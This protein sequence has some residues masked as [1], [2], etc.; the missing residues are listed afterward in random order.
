[1]R[2][3][4]GHFGLQPAGIQTCPCRRRRNAPY[5]RRRPL[6]KGRLPGGHRPHPATARKGPTACRD[7]L[8]DEDT[9][10]TCLC[11]HRSDA[12]T[13][14]GRERL[15]FDTFLPPN[16][17]DRVYFE[18]VIRWRTADPP[19]TPSELTAALR[20]EGCEISFPRYPLL[21]Q[22]PL[23]T[24]GLFTRIT[25]PADNAAP[26]PTF[27]TDALPATERANRELLRLPTFPGP[28]RSLI[29]QYAG[30]FEKV[31]VHASKIRQALA[32]TNVC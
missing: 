14:S 27:R 22:Q 2:K 10:G 24:E 13:A 11:G 16:H 31:L 29:D 18:F 32:P 1:M 9:D 7:Q 26:V 30:A 21:H 23:F 15:G 5:E 3:P 4:W 12:A 19:L 28:S 25:R 17:I 6:R 20:K 8:R